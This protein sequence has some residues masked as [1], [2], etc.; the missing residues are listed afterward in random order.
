MSSV[1]LREIEKSK[2]EC[3][4]KFFSELN[5]KLAVNNVLYEVVDNYGTSVQMVS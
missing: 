5:A 4:K 2:T 3:A 1:Q